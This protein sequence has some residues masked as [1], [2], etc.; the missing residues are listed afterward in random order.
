MN[1]P[2]TQERIAIVDLADDLQVCQ[3]R[4]FKIL[5]R[6]DI[7]PRQRQDPNRG[8]Q[9][10]AAGAAGCPAQAFFSMM[11]RLEMDSGVEQDSEAAADPG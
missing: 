10:V 7:R 4:I 6:L 8:D 5:R 2:S 3:Q 9:N 1:D 11:P